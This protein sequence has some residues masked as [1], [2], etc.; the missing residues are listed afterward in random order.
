MCKQNFEFSK[1]QDFRWHENACVGYYNSLDSKRPAVISRQDQAM[2][3]VNWLILS[4]FRIT[5]LQASNRTE[6]TPKVPSARALF[7]FTVALSRYY[8]PVQPLYE[9]HKRLSGAPHGNEIR[10]SERNSLKLLPE[11]A[12]ID[13]VQAKFRAFKISRFSVTR[14]CLRGLL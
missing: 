5:A 14:K 9:S 7:V 11:P 13:H 3:E 1:F 6:N 12:Q 10:A 2:I 8:S 4:D